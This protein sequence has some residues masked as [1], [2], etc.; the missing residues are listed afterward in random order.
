MK[1]CMRN[2]GIDAVGLFRG[3]CI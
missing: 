1:I 2:A 3:G